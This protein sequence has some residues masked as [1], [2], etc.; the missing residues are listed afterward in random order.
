MSGEP[1]IRRTEAKAY[2]GAWLGPGAAWGGA[3]GAAQIT[4]CSRRTAAPAA[5]RCFPARRAAAS[6][7]L[8][9][10]APRSQ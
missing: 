5:A 7:P 9:R 3:R 4:R 1:S 10:L 2:F 6:T 8:R